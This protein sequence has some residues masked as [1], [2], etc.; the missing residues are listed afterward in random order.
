MDNKTK[1]G[2]VFI[3]IKN[4]I[5]H[6]HVQIDLNHQDYT[7]IKLSIK[8]NEILICCVYNAPFPS[9]YQWNV[10]DFNLLTEKINRKAIELE[11]KHAIITDDVNFSQTNWNSMSSK[12][13]YQT[14]LLTKL[15]EYNF[16]NLAND[17]LDVVLCNNTES[18][19]NCVYDENL[20]NQICFNENFSNHKP[21]KTILMSKNP[22]NGIRS[23]NG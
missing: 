8:G 4:E 5:S 7:N 17:Q 13:L 21:I 11:C 10:S 14:E 19:I 9:Q 1:H 3:A 15:V 22:Q 16:C 6:D 12:N 18:I 2:G 23:F 20:A